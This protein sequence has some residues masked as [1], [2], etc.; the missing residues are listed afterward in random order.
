M[1]MMR[2]RWAAIGAAV[3]VTLGAGGIGLVS[4]TSPSNAATFVPITP[5]RVIDTRPDFQVGPRSAPLAANDTH[6]LAATGSAGDCTAVPATASGVV[7]NVT[8][9]DATLLTFLTIWEAGQPRPDSSSLN[10]A[11]GQPPTPNAVTTGIDGDG[12]FSIYNF[13]GTVHVIADIV[14]YYTDHDHDDRYYTETEVDAAIDAA[15]PF[16]VMGDGSTI[17]IEAGLFD[18][19]DLASSLDVAVPGPGQLVATATGNYSAV[20]S[21]GLHP[22]VQCSLTDDGT[23]DSNHRSLY[24]VWNATPT[25]T[26]S[27]RSEADLAI[28]R[29]IDVD[30][31]GTIEL[32]LLCRESSSGQRVLVDSRIVAQYLP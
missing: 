2:S 29:V 19:P 3:A 25:G 27:N 4:A 28:T 31:A 7:L 24:E 8:A 11:P 6:T 32:D 26:G 15:S 23:F 14:G 9:T 22:N 10:P 30:A 17:A 16:A 1:T 12:Q 13:Q 21:D 20:L 18:A 5:C